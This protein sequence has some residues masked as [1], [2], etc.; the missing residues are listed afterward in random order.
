MMRVIL[1]FALALSLSAQ[2]AS[3]PLA[4][5]VVDPRGE[6]VSITGVLQNL[7]PGI[8]V[9]V[10]GRI[11]SAS[12]GVNGG[13]VKTDSQLLVLNATGQV[14]SNVS[15]PPGS[16]L[17]G[18][19]QDGA[20][21]WIFYSGSSQIQSLDGS[22]NLSSTSLGDEV[23]ALGAANG[24][25]LA[26]LA[27]T[28]T[29][30]WAET[31]DVNSG[32]ILAQSPVNGTA[33]GVYFEGGWLVK[34]GAGMLWGAQE[35]STLAEVT[36]LQ[37]AGPH[38]VAIN[39]AW[40]LNS[41]WKVLE[42]PGASRIHNRIPDVSTRRL[43]PVIRWISI[44]AVACGIASGQV[45][46]QN[47]A[48]GSTVTSPFVLPDVGV[49]DFETVLLDVV[50]TGSSAVTV[51][52]VAATGLYFSLCC[53][54]GFVLQPSESQSLTLR[55]APTQTGNFSGSIQ[56]DSLTI[57]IFGRSLPDPTLFVQTKSGPVQAHS[58]TPLILTEDTPFSGQFPCVLEN[59]TSG[60]V[61]VQSISASGAWS[62]I[63]GP[64]LPLVL[65]AGQQ[66]TFTLFSG[67][68]PSSGTL[69][70]IVTIDQLTY[71]IDAHP[72]TP[73]IHINIPGSPLQSGQQATLSINFDSAPTQVV[74][75]TVLL[76]LETTGPVTLEDPAILFTSSGSTT[77]S[78]TSVVGQLSADF[79]GQTTLTFQTGTTEGTLHIE[80]TWGYSQD[81]VDVPLTA[82]PI[83]IE[84]VSA[85]RGSNTLGLTITGYDNT[86]SAGRMSFSFFDSQGAFIGNPVTSDFTQLFYNYFFQT[87]YN[88][89]GMFTMTALFPVT[90]G[91]GTISS[92]QVDLMNTAGDA[93]SPVTPFH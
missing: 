1:P 49:N 91:T 58:G 13:V 46:V 87:A 74:S 7:L 50:N 9:P 41:A 42:I 31:V 28:G 40:L 26:V 34:G 76:T 12:F 82:S 11:V 85:T 61:T 92:V 72:P 69:A 4:A 73:G 36:T 90:G 83:V 37:N 56:V 54:T 43:D 44:F 24:N 86:R 65:A 70:G 53:E 21:G 35:F 59:S 71:A 63:N 29:Q 6:L 8:P 33:P 88:A 57:F 60:P 23:I 47:H 51:Q 5:M 52:G 15:A 2:T 32:L 19:N 39:G 66:A 80:A 62:V 68:A 81:E 3:A 79:E 25:A 67:G 17:F 75:G 18:R 16:A 22:V 38:S 48:T 78:F 55:F 14:Q 10:P 27:R 93:Q 84:T 64:A 20:I 77:A 30:L 45:V 89:G